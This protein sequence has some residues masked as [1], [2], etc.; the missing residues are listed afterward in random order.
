MIHRIGCVSYLNSRP[1][2]E[3]LDELS[4]LRVTFD[5]PSGLL[6]DLETGRVD[7]ALCPVIDYHRSKVPLIIVPAGGIGC[8]GTTLTVRLF[9]RVPIEQITSIFADSDSHTSVALL[10][11]LL[12]RGRGLS[13]TIVPFHAGQSVAEVRPVEAP[14]AMLLIGDKVVT[15]CPDEAQ[16][17]HQVDLGQAWFEMTRMPFVFATWMA[18]RD[19]DL[20]DLPNILQ[21]RRELNAGR[22]DEIVERHAVARG[23]PKALAKKYLGSLLR[24]PVGEEE[25]HAI[26]QFGAWAAEAGAIEEARPLVVA[27]V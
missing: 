19:A 18:R 15:A 22:I 24:Y 11:V 16:Y 25:L 10:R 21:R 23:W 2:I 17:P 27:G 20:G 5:V 4:D 12:L 7:I 13:P 8:R 6:E 1:L 9:S 14:E 26:E 3:G